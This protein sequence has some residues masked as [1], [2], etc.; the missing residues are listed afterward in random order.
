MA[1]DPVSLEE[2]AAEYNVSRER[3]RQLEVRA[4]DKVQ[5]LVKTR[6]SCS[7]RQ[8]TWP[9]LIGPWNHRTWKHL[10][11]QSGLLPPFPGAPPALVAINLVLQGKRF[12][13]VSRTATSKIVPAAILRDARRAKA[14]RA[15]QMRGLR[16]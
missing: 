13:G 10:R 9:D 12:C 11:R 2:L 8:D 5:K 6:L 14:L 4:F 15:P 7:A 3:V 16:D 1:D